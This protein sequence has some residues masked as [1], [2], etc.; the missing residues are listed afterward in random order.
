MVGLVPPWVFPELFICWFFWL[1]FPEPPE[2]FPPP[3]PSWLFPFPLVFPFPLLFSLVFSLPPLLFPP[4]PLE[5]GSAPPELELL[6]FWFPV[7]S[8]SLVFW[9][10]SLV[11]PPV[12]FE[13]RSVPTELELVPFWFPVE[14]LLLELLLIAPEPV[15]SSSTLPLGSFTPLGPPPPCPGLDESTPSA[16]LPWPLFPLVSPLPLLLFSLEFW[17]PPLFVPPVPPELVPLPTAKSI[18][19]VSVSVPHSFTT[20]TTHWLRPGFS[21]TLAENTPL[22]LIVTGICVPFSESVITLFKP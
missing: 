8:L 9:F 20:F 5:F 19:K 14:P 6:P 15:L 12:P 3:E 2:L 16:L 17:F 1:P 13:L 10:P 22:E 11:A 21:V 7:V 18:L 4:V